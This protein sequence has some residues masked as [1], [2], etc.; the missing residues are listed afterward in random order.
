MR[1]GEQLVLLLFVFFRYDFSSKFQRGRGFF[2]KS[3][4]QQIAFEIVTQVIV[5][6]SQARF[7]NLEARATSQAAGDANERYGF[8]A[9]QKNQ[10]SAK[11]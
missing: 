5:F 8:R 6:L 4:I 1:Y 7:W 10:S 2:L 9:R 11:S 3:R